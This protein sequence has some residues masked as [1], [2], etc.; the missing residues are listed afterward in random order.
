MITT[1]AFTNNGSERVHCPPERPVEGGDLVTNANNV[2]GRAPTGRDER[3]LVTRRERYR[4][5]SVLWSVS[6]LKRVQGCGRWRQGRGGRGSAVGVYK[7]EEYA[8]FDGV[9]T[10]GSVWAC[11]VCAAKIRQ[12][13]AEEIREALLRHLGNGGGIVTQVL[14]IP[15]DAGDR[16]DC[17]FDLVRGGWR[18]LNQGRARYEVADR[19]G[20]VG[21]IRSSEVTHGLNGWHPHLHVLY[22]TERPLTASERA[23]LEST[24]YRR[25]A[26][27]VESEGHRKPM[28]RFCRVEVVRSAEDVSDYLC[29]VASESG[30]DMPLEMTRHD[31]KQGRVDP[32][33]VNQ[34]TPFQ[35]LRDFAETGDVDDL[36][37]WLE[38]EQASK[39]KHALDWSRGLKDL[40]LVEEQTDEELAEEEQG[41]SLV[42]RIM[43]SEWDL[44]IKYPPNACKILETAEQGDP[45]EVRLLVEQLVERVRGSP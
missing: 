42:M 2:S 29:K 41:G 18:R 21:T 30:W 28:Q 26:A 16:L 1:P 13:R 35:I 33:R 17:T 40:L 6:S 38:Y 5:R 37:L 14:T 36:N 15:H 44:L 22:L 19:I 31:L 39:G 7:R 11:P 20:L 43:P 10:C 4:L 8:Y 25:W 34:R 9:Q 45:T 12:R 23:W 32:S 3:R 27:H 24:Q